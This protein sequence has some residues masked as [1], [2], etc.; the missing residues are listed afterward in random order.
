MPFLD[1]DLK[2]IIDNFKKIESL[3]ILSWK[4]TDVHFHVAFTGLSAGLQT[5]RLSEAS[6]SKSTHYAIN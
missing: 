5:F 3:S 2:V 4:A 6:N 1:S